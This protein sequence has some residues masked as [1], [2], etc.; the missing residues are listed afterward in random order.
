MLNF[1]PMPVSRGG[2]DARH[3]VVHLGRVI[4]KTQDYFDELGNPAA[5]C[6]PLFRIGARLLAF[7]QHR[8]NHLGAEP[9]PVMSFVLRS[10]LGRVR[11]HRAPRNLVMLESQF[12]NNALAQKF[13]QTQIRLLG[14]P[15][16]GSEQRPVNAKSQN[17]NFLSHDHDLWLLLAQPEGLAMRGRLD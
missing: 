11:T 13:R 2:V 6:P 17:L 4:Q 5:P 14:T 8:G 1:T 15:L 10:N 16:H 7:Q 9:P 12:M 3:A